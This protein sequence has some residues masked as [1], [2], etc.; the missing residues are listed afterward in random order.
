VGVQSRIGG[1]PGSGGSKAGE[2]GGGGLGAS[3]SHIERT[4]TLLNV[5]IL[6]Y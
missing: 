3:L 6:A 4:E 5:F 2:R 1:M